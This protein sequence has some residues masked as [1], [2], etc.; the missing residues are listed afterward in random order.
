MN[1]DGHSKSKSFRP[2]WPDSDNG[3]ESGKSFAQNG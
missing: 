1:I 2:L 3:F